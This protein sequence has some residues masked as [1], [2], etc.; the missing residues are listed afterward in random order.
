VP[1]IHQQFSV[2]Y[3]FPVV[4]TRDLFNPAN[5]LLADT[6]D[7]RHERRRHRLLAFVDGGVLDHHPRLLDDLAAYAR[8]YADRMEWVL[9]PRRVIGG[10]SIKNDYRLTME[11]VDTIL[12]CGLCRH[13][14]VVAIGGGAVLDAV[15]FAASIVHRGL[16]LVRVPTTVL[17]Q[18]DSG[19]GVKTG[20]N[21][22]GGKNTI[23]T[24]APP[25]AVLNDLDFLRTL[26]DREWRAGVA[27]AFKVAMIKDAGFFET[28]IGSAPALAARDEAAMERLV[29]RCATLHLEHI[30]TSGDPFEQGTARP[31][32]FGHWAAHK[33]EALSGYRI[34][35]GDAV[36]TGIAIDSRYACRSGWLRAEEVDALVRGLQQCGFPL[37]HPE[38]A[39][40]AADGQ[41]EILNGL[42]DF[43]EHLG[44]ELTLTFPGPLG[45]RREVHEVDTTL[46][47]D[48]IAAWPRPIAP[49]VPS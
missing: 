20:M 36:A 31:L 18:N 10:E 25:F 12:E 34:G 19:V 41:P 35:H 27:E 28:L 47:A 9:P 37:W 6:L 8:R 24:F 33:L 13:S 21:L 7:R 44:G 40:R 38:L 30:R 39:R 43:Q 29:V 11:L 22:H 23:G 1:S 2:P 16:R 17:S 15:G 45:C 4:F 42:R 14:G 5:P 48:L 46:L 49:V 32:D 3:D 26:P